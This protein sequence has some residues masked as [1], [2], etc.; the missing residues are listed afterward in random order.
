MEFTPYDTLYLVKM[1]NILH[2]VWRYV[3][4]EYE[5]ESFNSIGKSKKEW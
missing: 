2:K 3:I 1:L 4:Y 5:K